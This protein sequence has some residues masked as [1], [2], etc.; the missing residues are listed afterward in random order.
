MLTNGVSL[1]KTI[2]PAELPTNIAILKARAAVIRIQKIKL[3][4]GKKKRGAGDQNWLDEPSLVGP[5]SLGVVI[6]KVIKNRKVEIWESYQATE[7]MQWR[8]KRG[9]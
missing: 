9:E 8:R 7:S 5:V 1:I 3:D 6:K 2:I 4:G